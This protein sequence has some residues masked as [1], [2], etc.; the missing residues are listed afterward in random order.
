MK[1]LFILASLVFS[2]IFGIGVNDVKAIEIGLD[3]DYFDVT[4]TEAYNQFYF[5]NIIIE[6]PE[7]AIEVSF[8]IDKDNAGSV[9]YWDSQLTVWNTQGLQPTVTYYDD[10]VHPDN[11]FKTENAVNVVGSNITGNH[12]ISLLGFNPNEIK[13]VMVSYMSLRSYTVGGPDNGIYPARTSDWVNNL[14]NELEGSYRLAD[15]SVPDYRWEQRGSDYTSTWYLWRRVY[16]PDGANLVSI[17][18][19][20]NAFAGGFGFRL[21]RSSNDYTNF[22]LSNITFYDDTFTYIDQINFIDNTPKMEDFYIT[23]D[24]P[25]RAMYYEVNV[26][27]ATALTTDVLESMND[28][29][30]IIY[31]RDLVSVKL[32]SDNTLIA[33]INTYNNFIWG[34]MP[35]PIYYT[36]RE[37]I[38][39]IYPD[40][41][42]FIADA[43][44]NLDYVVDGQLIIYAEY[45]DT[46]T[47]PVDDVPPRRT[48]DFE[49]F[50]ASLGFSST[51]GYHIL[52]FLIIV[53][54]I[55]IVALFDLPGILSGLL[56]LGVAG[57]FFALGLINFIT[58]FVILLGFGV[59]MVFNRRSDE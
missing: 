36:N 9:A 26:G 2:L 25:E 37:F 55:I 4:L 22:N 5:T 18:F 35:D 56:S 12:R 29:I 58:M 16:V 44:I 21:N 45:E 43:L 54:I 41:S 49:M 34:D 24:I 57:L 32:Y 30:E 40:G 27:I 15:S 7:N 52:L 50:F 17:K 20:A 33:T 28:A 6:V 46:T 1:K 59:I 13:F 14:V 42:T 31:D 10:V 48:T 11:L 8:S 47:L 3:I 19:P 39:W 53:G 23:F 38:R 51:V